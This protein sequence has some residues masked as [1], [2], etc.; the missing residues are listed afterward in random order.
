MQ[1]EYRYREDWLPR[2]LWILWIAEIMI[3]G[4]IIGIIV[5]MHNSPQPAQLQCVSSWAANV[6]TIICK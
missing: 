4:F 1:K 5:G 2:L 6:L 3:I